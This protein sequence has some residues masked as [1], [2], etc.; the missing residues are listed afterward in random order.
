MFLCRS[1]M[2]R[3]SEASCRMWGRSFGVPQL[4]FCHF[5]KHK[6]SRFLEGFSRTATSLFVPVVFRGSEKSTQHMDSRAFSRKRGSENG[7][8]RAQDDICAH[9]SS[10][11]GAARRREGARDDND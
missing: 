9:V 8:S 4:D 5:W 6:N 11:A 2:L 7:K 10:L 3:Y 1:A